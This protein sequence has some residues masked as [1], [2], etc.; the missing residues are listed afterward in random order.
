M[1]L[2]PEQID[3]VDESKIPGYAAAAEITD[4]VQQK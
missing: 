2:D 4:A 1:F 3:E